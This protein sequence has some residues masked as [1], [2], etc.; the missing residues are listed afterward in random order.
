[1]ALLLLDQ[2]IRGQMPGRR[3]GKVDSSRQW[4][5]ERTEIANAYF[6]FRGLYVSTDTLRIPCD[7]G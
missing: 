6:V 2:L 5:Q 1:M 4:Y 7:S 3:I